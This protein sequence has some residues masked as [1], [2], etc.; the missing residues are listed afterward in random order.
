MKNKLFL[1]LVLASAAA[2]ASE[3]NPEGSDDEQLKN[4]PG[5]EIWEGTIAPRKEWAVFGAEGCTGSAI[6]PNYIL[7]ASHC[8]CDGDRSKSGGTTRFWYSSN[9][10]NHTIGQPPEPGTF[11]FPPV[12][13]IMLYHL[14]KTHLLDYYAPIDLDYNPTDGDTGQIYGYGDHG[15]G[16]KV[17]DKNALYQANVEIHYIQAGGSAAG[18]GTTIHISGIDGIALPGVSGGALFSDAANYSVVGVGST[19]EAQ[20]FHGS[21]NYADLKQ[22]KNFILQKTGEGITGIDIESS[23][24]YPYQYGTVYKVAIKLSGKGLSD[25]QTNLMVSSSNNNLFV[26]K[27]PPGSLTRAVTILPDE[28]GLVIFYV[29]SI[30]T[31]NK[32]PKDGQLRVQAGKIV[33]NIPV[34]QLFK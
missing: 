22:V 15:K 6:S 20:N 28:N 29:G 2:H 13:D 9:N 12:G 16:T 27:N 33:K 10:N 30:T 31:H 24:F 11:Y 17:E 32:I 25:A 5:A 3:F 26:T 34:T 8:K 14:D 4:K 7:S 19:T 21:A 18:G 23:V 1:L